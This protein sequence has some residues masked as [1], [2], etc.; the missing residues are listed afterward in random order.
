[1]ITERQYLSGTIIIT[2]IIEENSWCMRHQVGIAD[3]LKN[4]LKINETFPTQS[5]SEV[6][7]W[8]V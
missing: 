5:H 2:L 7:F 6:I 3:D 8:T 1:M 4:Q